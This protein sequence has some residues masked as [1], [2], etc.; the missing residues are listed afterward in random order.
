M[1]CVFNYLPQEV[2]LRNHICTWLGWVSCVHIRGCF[3]AGGPTL[4]VLVRGFFL[5]W[6]T[7]IKDT[8]FKKL[9]NL[10]RVVSSSACIF[11][12]T[13]HPNPNE[14]KNRI[15]PNVDDPNLVDKQMGGNFLF[16]GARMSRKMVT[17]KL[18]VT[19]IY[20]S[21]LWQTGQLIMTNLN[22]IFN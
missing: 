11:R 2:Y 7:L 15:K 12:V 20:S 19:L 5:F 22:I 6:A 4:T 10:A 16:F 18:L 8:L 1:V 9:Q 3:N 21:T 17:R 14:K 13:P